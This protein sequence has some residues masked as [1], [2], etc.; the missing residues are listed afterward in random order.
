MIFVPSYSCQN[1]SVSDKPLPCSSQVG[2]TK[3]RFGC[4]FPGKE[5]TSP[6]THCPNQCINLL[7]VNYFLP[8]EKY[9]F[10]T[11]YPYVRSFLLYFLSSEHN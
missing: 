9:F 10:P 6:S 7:S 8:F 2:L 1:V 4:L 11:E 5:S 3:V